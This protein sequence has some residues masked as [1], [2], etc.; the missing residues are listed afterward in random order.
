MEQRAEILA[1]RSWGEFG[2]FLAAQRL[3][4]V[5][6]PG[7]PGVRL[8]VGTAEEFFPRLGAAGVEIREI[9]VGSPT[10]QVRTRRYMAMVERLEAHYPPGFEASAASP[11]LQEEL[12]P[13]AEHFRATRPALVIGTKGINSRLA[14]AALRQAGHAAPVLNYVTNP[15]LLEI[16]I[17]RSPHVLNV[18]P[19]E[20]ARA[21]LLAEPGFAAER[22]VVAGPLI[23]EHELKGFLVREGGDG[24]AREPWGADERRPKLIVFCNRGGPEYLALV[25]HL[26]ARHGGV[27]LVF[28]SYNHTALTRAAAEVA[29]EAGHHH[30]RFHDSLRQAEYFEYVERA[31]RSAHA[32]LITKSGPNSVLEAAFFGI[33]V[34]AL[35]S[36]LPMEAWVGPMI[37]E[38][39]LGRCCATMDEVVGVLDGWIADGAVVAEHKASA[40][41]FAARALDQEAIAGRLRRAVSGILGGEAGA[42]AGAGTAEEERGC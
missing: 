14:L 4:K 23:A 5:L 31:S 22:I 41:A 7:L 35:E 15:G 16:S 34:L 36:G 42:L 13:L 11:A 19:T 17:H 30:W 28:I 29:A 21:R 27:D 40:R 39:G 20:R 26:A 33:P 37:E 32:L 3:A 8:E 18:V 9:T 12:A 6:A 2:N 1:M 25:R 38:E 10:P 24:G